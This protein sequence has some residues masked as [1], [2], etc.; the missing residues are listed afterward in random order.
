MPAV[1][2]KNAFGKFICGETSG[3]TFSTAVRPNSSNNCPSGFLKCSENTS[4]DF[5]I[6]VPEG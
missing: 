5:S 2:Q 4:A 6:C 1:T 3:T